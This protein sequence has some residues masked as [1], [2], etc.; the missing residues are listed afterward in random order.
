MLTCTPGLNSAM[1]CSPQINNLYK[2][3]YLGYIDIYHIVGF[4]TG[5]GKI[6][7]LNDIENLTKLDPVEVSPHQPI[8]R[9]DEHN[10]K[11]SESLKKFNESDKGIELR[12]KKSERMKDFYASPKGQAIKERLSKK[13]GRPKPKAIAKAVR[14]HIANEYKDGK[15]IAELARHYNVS[16]ASIYRYIREFS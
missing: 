11:I 12:K 6:T 4:M 10:E 13:C 8:K 3:A 16:R 1:F 2:Y 14:K 9:K 15:K 7:S 5:L